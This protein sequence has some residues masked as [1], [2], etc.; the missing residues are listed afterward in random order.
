[1]GRSDPDNPA[2]L[3]AFLLLLSRDLKRR[4]LPACKGGPAGFR[5]GFVDILDRRTGIWCPLF[6]LLM[7]LIPRWHRCVWVAI[8]SNT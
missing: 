7:D 8:L 5:D 4:S 1:M 2:F 6:G 3:R